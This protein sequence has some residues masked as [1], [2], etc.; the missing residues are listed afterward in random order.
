[1]LVHR[2][3]EPAPDPAPAEAVDDRD[4]ELG[5]LGIDVAVTVLLLGEQPVPDGAD[6][7]AGRLGDEA[8][9]PGTAQPRWYIAT[10]GRSRTT[11]SGPS[12]RRRQKSA[13]TSIRR[14][15]G[16]SA[17]VS[18]RTFRRRSGARRS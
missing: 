4:G 11:R 3:E 16:R 6:R 8:R 13:V 17:G 18:G 10:C 2:L 1:V 9:I 15:K 7:T 12:R 14:R 5:R